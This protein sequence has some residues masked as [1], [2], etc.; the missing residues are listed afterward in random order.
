M[1]ARAS[2]PWSNGL[3]AGL[4]AVVIIGAVQTFGYRHE[5]HL[6]KHRDCNERRLNTAT[7]AETSLGAVR[8]M[9]CL[10]LLILL[11]LLGVAAWRDVATRAIPNTISLLIVLAGALSR[12]LVGPLALALSAATAMSIFLLLM[13]AFSR[14]LLGGGDVKIMTALAVGLSP[15]N[16]WRFVLVTAIAGGFL[17][18]AYILLSHKKYRMR[19]AKPASLLGRIA[20]VEFWRIRRRGPLPYGVAIAAG[21]AF[22]LLHPGSF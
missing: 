14:G 3:L 2:R 17:A 13:I 7:R 6:L 5:H 22:V 1:I 16:S 18:V 4:I 19:G 11:V 21:G 9:S 15:F 12:V 8:P 20:Q 10:L